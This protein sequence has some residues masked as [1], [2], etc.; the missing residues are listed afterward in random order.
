MNRQISVERD[1]TSDD[2]RYLL[3]QDVFPDLTP[4]WV[5]DD[6]ERSIFDLRWPDDPRHFVEPAA[7]DEARRL[8]GVDVGGIGS[9]RRVELIGNTTMVQSLVH[10]WAL[11]APALAGG[12][13]VRTIVHVDDH[14]DLMSVLIRQGQADGTFVD[15]IDGTV[16][17]V[18]DPDTVI[19]AIE[20][21]AINKANFM[22]AYLL[23]HS[24]TR[25]IYVHPDEPV[26]DF[27]LVAET[28]DLPAL[29]TLRSSLVREPCDDSRAW[30]DARWLRRRELPV[31]LPDAGAVWLDIDLDYFCNRFDGDSDRLQNESSEEE[32]AELERRLTLFRN[33]LARAEWIRDIVAVSIAVSPGFLPAAHWETALGAVA[34]VLRETIGGN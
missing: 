34:G 24:E 9:F 15:A 26:A 5:R 22:T 27:S 14:T 6:E 20:R 31:R 13:P 21:G 16:V 3:V 12:G 1:A 11:L 28:E 4:C 17:S 33:G 29:G 32:H 23:A 2:V 10:G 25:V 18:N 8:F 19:G 30:S 7:A